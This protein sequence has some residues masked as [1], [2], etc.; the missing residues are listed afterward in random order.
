ML[1]L[2]RG[3]SEVF[4]ARDPEV[5]SGAAAKAGPSSTLQQLANV[6]GWRR[7]DGEEERE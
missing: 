5:R 7:L 4:T 1:D 3:P 6:G 2:T